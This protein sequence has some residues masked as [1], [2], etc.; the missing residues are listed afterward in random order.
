MQAACKLSAPAQRRKRSANERACRLKL[1]GVRRQIDPQRSV[2]TRIV[3][4]EQAREC[5]HQHAVQQRRGGMDR[6]AALPRHLQLW[7]PRQ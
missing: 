1:V 3:A 6:P 7:L 4:G 5:V 2:A